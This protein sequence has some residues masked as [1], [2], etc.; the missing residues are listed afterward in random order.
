MVSAKSHKDRHGKV[1]LELMHARKFSGTAYGLAGKMRSD[2]RSSIVSNGDE[3]ISKRRTLCEQKRHIC[4][5]ICLIVRKVNE[6][7]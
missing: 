6:S 4:Y 7:S 3:C 2:A 1:N 5:S